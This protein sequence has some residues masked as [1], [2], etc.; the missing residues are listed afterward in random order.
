MYDTN[1]IKRQQHRNFSPRIDVRNNFT[2]YLFDHWWVMK[3]N[4]TQPLLEHNWLITSTVCLTFSLLL[5]LFFLTRT[6]HTQHET[7]VDVHTLNACFR[8]LCAHSNYGRH[9][10]YGAVF[11]FV[12]SMA[13]DCFLSYLSAFVR[14]KFT[15]SMIHSS[16]LQTTNKWFVFDFFYPNKFIV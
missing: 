8:H 9:Y 4:F 11:V 12:L 5:P 16:L 2:V 14:I 3:R 1:F 15:Q 10:Y 13:G 7:L 6:I